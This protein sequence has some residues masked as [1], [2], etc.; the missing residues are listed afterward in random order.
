M[1]V[2][3]STLVGRSEDS[4][5]SLP[6][7]CPCRLTLGRG[8][9]LFIFNRN[10]PL[11]DLTEFVLARIDEEE[12]AW[13][14]LGAQDPGLW[15]SMEKGLQRCALKRRTVEALETK[16]SKRLQVEVKSYALVYYDHPNYDPS[17]RPK[18]V[19]F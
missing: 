7:H 2:P 15:L 10:T 12:A 4:A 11:V 13:R 8:T 1:P 9:D 3:P 5:E 16:P 14:H 18:A 6:E 17:W 19:R